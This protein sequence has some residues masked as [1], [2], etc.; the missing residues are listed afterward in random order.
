MKNRCSKL[1]VKIIY[2][3][4][5]GETKASG[6]SENKMNAEL[7]YILKGNGTQH[8]E[9]NTNVEKNRRKRAGEV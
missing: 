7:I 8:K 1:N 3:E 4:H 9:V 2:N 5:L 6:S